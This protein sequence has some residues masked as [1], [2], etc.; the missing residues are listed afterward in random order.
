MG[1]TIDDADVID[2]LDYAGIW[3]HRG[4]GHLIRRRG[5]RGTELSLT[6]RRK[7]LG[8]VEG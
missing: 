7:I 2:S 6:Y 5:G 1:Q 3:N 8:A 4:L